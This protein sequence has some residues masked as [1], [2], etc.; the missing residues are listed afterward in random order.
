MHEKN[1][2]IAMK[3]IYHLLLLL[4]KDWNLWEEVVFF[5]Y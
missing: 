1:Q 4:N 3:Y 2:N 5:L